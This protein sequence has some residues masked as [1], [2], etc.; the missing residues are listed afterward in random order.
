LKAEFPRKPLMDAFSMVASVVPSRSPK[1]ILQNIMLSV[2]D[3]KASIQ[4]TDLEVAIRREID[5]VFAVDD[6]HVILPTDRFMQIL[7]TSAADTISIET[8]GDK[9]LIKG[10]GSRFSLPNED[11]AL[12]PVLPE[13]NATNYMTLLGFDL[14]RLIKRTAF[15][16]DVDSARYALGGSFVERE[17]DSICF[18][19]TDG[20]RLA[21]ASAKAEWVGD[22]DGSAQ[23]I[24]PSK[25][26]KLIDK[27]ISDDGDLIHF[28]V[29]SGTSAMFRTSDSVIST[30]L[31]EGR[32]P[33][34]QDVFPKEPGVA[35]PLDVA[36]F[37][38]AIEQA[39]ITTSEESRG[40]SFRFSSEGVELS[41]Q[42][43]DVGESRV[44]LPLLCAMGDE[45]TVSM[46][47]RFTLEMLRALDA[48]TPLT[49]D[50]VDA[51]TAVVF[52]SE[53]N[54][55]YVVMPLTRD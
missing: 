43:S 10:K 41:C 3:G 48:A 5:G 17:A 25:A 35:I 6:G 37:R 14:K 53:E 40:V 33:K 8:D 1:P 52:K 27:A 34:Y 20:R 4:G 49:V 2:Q 54:Y 31:V 39:S 36:S 13:F 29:L 28:S 26:L 46:D 30:R 45:I 18:V 51:K 22:V 19:A 11:T 47:P 38:S 55:T 44:E 21:R 32:F 16:V 12:F 7:R 42:S 15:A 24:L 50:L 23:C 9:L